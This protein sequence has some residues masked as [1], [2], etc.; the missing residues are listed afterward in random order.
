LS[1]C[2]VN[3]EFTH[4]DPDKSSPY[5]ENI[6]STYP[7]S[8]GLKQEQIAPQTTTNTTTLSTALSSLSI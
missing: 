3:A 7:L 1:V 6:L 8:A 5:D 2:P 4:H